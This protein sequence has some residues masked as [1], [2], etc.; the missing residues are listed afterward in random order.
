MLGTEGHTALQ[1]ELERL[2]SRVICSYSARCAARAEVRE[3]KCAEDRE[4]YVPGVFFLV[5]ADGTFAM[6]QK[7]SN[8]PSCWSGTRSTGNACRPGDCL[9]T[10][11]RRYALEVAVHGPPGGPDVREQGSERR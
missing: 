8:G 9:R 4:R 11:G 7:G 6:A 3:R 1:A 2:S 10:W 5:I